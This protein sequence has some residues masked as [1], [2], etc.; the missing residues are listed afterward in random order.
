MEKSTRSIGEER[1]PGVREILDAAIQRTG[2]DDL[3]DDWFLTPLEA[4]A[5]D[6]EESNLTERGRGFMRSLAV[7]DV[8]RRLRVLDTLR[9]HPEIA[10]VPLPPV[11]YITGLERS[12]TTLLHNLMALRADARALLRWELME[13]VPPP[14]ADDHAT[15]PRIAAV[16]A[17]IEPLRGSRLEQMHWVEAEDPEECAW[18]FI[19]AVSMLGQA[20]TFCMPRWQRFLNETD[21]T[22]AFAHYRSVVQLLTWR[23]PVPP[24]GRLVLKSPQ[25]G[26]Q[27]GAFA[28]VFPEARFVVT[29]RDPFRALSSLAFMGASIVEP[30]CVENPLHRRGPDDIDL[31][32][33]V[34]AK[35]AAIERFSEASPER[36]EHVAYPALASDPAD[37][38]LDLS[39]RLD[40]PPDP[41]HR[42]RIEA[43]LAAQRTGR[44]AAPPREVDAMGYDHAG[45]LAEPRITRYCARFGIEPERERMTG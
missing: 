29:D 12:G 30:F 21:L 28:E 24:G 16:Q 42:D 1:G 2:L 33:S 14:T 18:G 22:P 19:D 38:A 41:G 7:R 40:L 31:L 6:L 43:F 34:A 26:L 25:I 3:G 13:P 17:S 36:I 35:L 37:T 44:R 27:I 39:D 32:E 45:V 20:A 4:W 10:D 5:K 23:N 11:V 8:A 9:A 15:D